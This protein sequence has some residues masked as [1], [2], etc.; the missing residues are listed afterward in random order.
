MI[1]ESATQSDHLKQF[2]K[3]SDQ[4]VKDP[5]M[6]IS[7]FHSNASNVQTSNNFDRFPAFNIEANKSNTT[8]ETA[9]FQETQASKP[10]TGETPEEKRRR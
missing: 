6:F 3:Y 9:S 5:K 7:G 4:R 1:N 10:K 2:N 8:T